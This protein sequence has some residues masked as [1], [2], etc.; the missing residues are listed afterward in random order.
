MFTVQKP[1]VQAR[2]LNLT[3]DAGATATFTCRAS[4][5]LLAGIEWEDST[6][7]RVESRRGVLTISN[8]RCEYFKMFHNASQRVVHQYIYYFT[9][10]RSCN[11]VTCRDFQVTCHSCSL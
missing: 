9:Q 2:P 3:I 6:G 7:R 11:N 5:D 4:G 10:K 8:A 1:R